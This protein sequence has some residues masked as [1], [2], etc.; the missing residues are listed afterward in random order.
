MVNKR[1]I[2]RNEC[3][4]TWVIYDV[5]YN[6]RS[7]FAS[8]LEVLVFNGDQGLEKDHLNI[9]IVAELHLNEHFQL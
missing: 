7:G 6:S 2:E 5:E 8:D 3:P 1:F 9:C 4:L